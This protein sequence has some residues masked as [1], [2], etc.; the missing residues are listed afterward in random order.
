MIRKRSATI[1]RDFSPCPFH[2]KY[3]KPAP[4]FSP[5]RRI[6]LAASVIFLALIALP[7]V[8]A[9][10]ASALQT[11]CQ[12][13]FGNMDTCQKEIAIKRDNPEYCRD[14]GA[15]STRNVCYIYF[16]KSRNDPSFCAF[17]RKERNSFADAFKCYEPFIKSLGN[18]TLCDSFERD[19]ETQDDCYAKVYKI[20][21]NATVC[22]KFHDPRQKIKCYA[23][24][25]KYTYDLR[26]CD[27]MK[28]EVDT[29]VCKERKLEAC[30]TAAHL[31][32]AVAKCRSDASLQQRKDRCR[33]Y[34]NEI[35]TDFS[36]GDKGEFIF[37]HDDPLKEAF[38]VEVNGIDTATG[39]AT[40]G[41][42]AGNH[43]AEYHVKTGN[44]MTHDFINMFVVDIW[45][46]QPEAEEGKSP[47]SPISKISL[48]LF[49]EPKAKE[50]PVQPGET[51]QVQVNV[52]PAENATQPP[53]ETSIGEEV[54][55]EEVVEEA[56][57]GQ[58]VEE[59]FV[60]RAL[61]W[62]WSLF[63]LAK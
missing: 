13:Q 17:V 33:S 59:G 18:L 10:D 9:D 12:Q 20:V 62:F 27:A 28:K 36:Q 15:A 1:V 53:V 38:S 56:V 24:A 54:V 49:R 23:S 22:P 40:V 30:D 45:K 34:D 14:I 31:D 11:Y 46:E 52:T 44:I 3:I 41:I 61:R 16:A 47:P 39:I 50:A 57:D 51:P 5:M 55:E 25:A 60:R 63:G 32:D 6:T 35:E 19:D 37:K 8:A 58:V 26:Y 4:V 7:I 48:C 42:G 43:K 2:E 21:E 29:S